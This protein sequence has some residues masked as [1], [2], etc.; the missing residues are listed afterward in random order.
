MSFGFPRLNSPQDAFYRS[1]GNLYPPIPPLRVL[2]ALASPFLPLVIV[3]GQRD[4]FPVTAAAITPTSRGTCTAS[5]MTFST[6]FF[7]LFAKC[8]RTAREKAQRWKW[9]DLSDG[10]RGSGRLN[11]GDRFRRRDGSDCAIDCALYQVV[12][13]SALTLWLTSA[14]SCEFFLLSESCIFHAD[15]G[16]ARCSFWKPRLISVGFLTPFST[17]SFGTGQRGDSARPS[18]RTRSMSTRALRGRHYRAALTAR[19][20]MLRGKTAVVDR[21]HMLVAHTYRGFCVAYDC[22][23]CMAC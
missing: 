8:R 19:A 21:Q 7:E 15:D 23:E 3:I 17:I 2:G 16:M 10:I 20:S 18:I 6:A 12:V 22:R 13:G 14:V 1:V 11:L 9:R 5:V 4:R